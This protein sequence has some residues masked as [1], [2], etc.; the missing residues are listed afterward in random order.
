ML[1]KDFPLVRLSDLRR[2]PFIRGLLLGLIASK[3]S[4]LRSEATKELAESVILSYRRARFT[5]TLLNNKNYTGISALDYTKISQRQHLLDRNV[6]HKRLL[7]GIGQYSSNVELQ[8]ATML[9]L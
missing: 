3:L 4:A 2:A 7:S 1:L 6:Y 8:H 5:C 9:I